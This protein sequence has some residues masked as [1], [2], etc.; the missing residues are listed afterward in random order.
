[1]KTLVVRVSGGLGNQMFEYALGLAVSQ[2]T[3]RVLR[4][5]LTDFLVFRS[6][7]TYQLDQ[8]CGPRATRRWGTVQTGLFLAAWIIG[9]RI[10]MGLATAL[11]RILNVCVIQTDQ[12]FHVDPGFMNALLAG[13]NAT[14][15][16]AGC[17]GVLP[18]LADA[19]DAIREAFTLTSELS[20]PNKTYYERFSNTASSVSIH[21][22]R[23]DYLSANNGAP[24]LDFTY[25]ARAIH[26][27]R[28]RVEDP[29]WVIFSDDIPWCRNA[30]ADLSNVVYVEGN[31][32]APWC[33]MHLIS[34]CRH[35]IIANSTFSWWGAFLSRAPSGITVYPQTWFRGQPTT[36]D[37]VNPTW[38]PVA[39]SE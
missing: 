24:V 35:H 28:Q 19:T 39:S 17:Y 38:M 37:M 36:A 21:I 25:Y 34:A 26:T 18:Y 22:R 29:L 31:A 11:F 4:L 16:I 7:R 33:D 1:M 23:T 27:I 14:L 13:T 6:G 20:G 3:G 30:F 9:K 15:C 2:R 12:L 32:D 10:S 8:F 5:D